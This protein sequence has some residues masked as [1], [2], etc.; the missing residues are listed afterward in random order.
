MT[1]A[2]LPV[3]AAWVT[4]FGDS[5]ISIDDRTFYPNRKDLIRALNLKGLKVDRKGTVSCNGKG[6]KNAS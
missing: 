1:I 2:Y 6:D 5:I 3:N 4:L